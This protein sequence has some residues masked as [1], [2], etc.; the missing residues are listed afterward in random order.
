MFTP[1]KKGLFFSYVKADNA[2][3]LVNTVDSSEDKYTVKQY[4][5]APKAW[6]M[7]D[8][9]GGPSTKDYIRYV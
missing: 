3:I 1:S 8:I 7:Q 4:Y 5:D 9:I 6:S 2:H